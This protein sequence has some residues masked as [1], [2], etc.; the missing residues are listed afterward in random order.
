MKKEFDVKG[1][2]CAACQAHV[3]KAVEKIKGV[4]KVS[5]NL[6]TN[7]M[8]VDYDGSEALTAEIEEAVH[9]AGYEAMLKGI[10]EE[11]KEKQKKFY[12][13]RDF[14]KL[15]ISF[16]F[17]ILLMIFSMGPMFGMPLPFFLEGEENA[18]SFTLVQMLLATP[19]LLIYRERFINGFRLLFKFHPNMDSLIALGAGASYLYGLYCLF[20]ISYALGQGD[21]ATIHTY[22]H[23]LH[24]ESAAMILTLVSLGKYLEKLA[25]GKTTKELSKLVALAPEN[26]RVLIGD[27]EEI[28]PAK[29]IKVNDTVILKKGDKVAVDG[30]LIEGEA[31][32]EESS[33]TGESLPVFKKE[34]EMVYS[35]TLVLNG[36]AKLKAEKVGEDTS[37]GTIVRL[38]KEA[39]Q[40]KAPVSRLVDRISLVFVPLV[41]L[42][43]IISFIVHIS[44]TPDFAN[45]F[46]YG[47]SVLVVACPCA[48]G[49]ATPVAIM[50]GSG[51]GAANGLLMKDASILENTHKIKTI[52]FDKTG[53]LTKGKMEVT[54]FLLF[55]K[56]KKEK[57]V[58]ERLHA[59]ESLSSHPLA[60]SLLNYRP[61]SSEIKVENF[62]SYDGVGLEGKIEGATYAAGNRRSL[63][64][65][66]DDKDE[67]K[68]K[69]LEK[70]GKTIIFLSENGRAIAS[71]ALKD[72][73][74]E[75]SKAAIEY[76]KKRKI[77]T[78]LLSGDKQETAEAIAHELGI[79]EVRAEVLPE[80]KGT[81]VASYLDPKKKKLVAMVGDGVN[82]A[83]ALS[84]ADIGISLGGGSDIAKETADI[85]LIRDDPLDIINAFRLSKRTMMTIYT[86]LLWAFAYNLVGIVLATGAFASLGVH[87]DPMISSLCMSFSSVLV[88]L[89]SLSLNFFKATRGENKTEEACACQ[90]KKGGEKE[91]EKITLNVEGMMCMMCVKHVQESLEKVVGV[92]SVEVSLD[93]KSASITGEHL[94]KEELIAAIEKAGYKAD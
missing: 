72:A 80:E 26:A 31:S 7:D 56:N 57:F 40:S 83:I 25:K 76:L 35:G 67:E 24:F 77:H 50:V 49:L 60:V 94:N 82:D 47:V 85:I 27:K 38:V 43:A 66:L 93:A 12:Q 81:V 20:M 41:L 62:M 37:I 61:S 23:A 21:L 42:I 8:A 53:T 59:L 74:K 65:A 32:F 15:M 2:S 46:N 36:H 63:S 13:D 84:R 71:F 34:G 70:E 3:Q 55:D 78:I 1:M 10:K 58:I 29:D 6:L 86:N 16:F 79:E 18:V 52:I 48:L 4:K 9:Q 90:L 39:S 68:V 44:L 33:I 11:K 75:N 64:Y 54:D 14:Q 89:T 69:A 28:I 73:L 87:L 92:Q 5:V 91:M 17:L 19:S 45:A 30:H 88:V 51:K 22:Q